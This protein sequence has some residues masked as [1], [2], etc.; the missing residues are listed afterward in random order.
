M[1]VILKIVFSSL[2]FLSLQIQ[3]SMSKEA[4]SKVSKSELSDN[5]P[6]NK[7]EHDAWLKERFSEQHQKLIPI[8][9]VADMFFICNQ[10]RKVD[11]YDY[12]LADIIN[13][14]DKNILAEKL[15]L[16]LGTDKMQSDIALNFGLLGCFHDQVSHLPEQERKQKMKLVKQAIASLSL[17]ERKKSFTQCVTEQAIGYLK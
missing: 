4:A 13:T 9:A 10:E 12:A 1:K 11:E 8:V 3:A 16:C 15:G 7:A 2:F 5:E 17:K 14:M 6:V